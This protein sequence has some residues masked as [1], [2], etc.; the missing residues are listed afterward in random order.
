[1]QFLDPGRL[2][3][4]RHSGRTISRRL[5]THSANT[6]R[7]IRRLPH[8]QQSVGRKN[9]AA[10]I[11]T[12]SVGAFFD[13]YFDRDV[14]T[15][16]SSTADSPWGWSPNGR[17]HSQTHRPKNRLELLFCQMSTTHVSSRALCLS[18]SLAGCFAT[19]QLFIHFNDFKK[20]IYSTIEFQ[21]STK[22]SLN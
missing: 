18:L 15:P 19:K 7:E 16:D 12:V 4:R 11:R 13:Y 5:R 2:T 14:F 10:L 22:Q 6:R 8:S 9:T 21:F 17:A 1:M 20:Q 3:R